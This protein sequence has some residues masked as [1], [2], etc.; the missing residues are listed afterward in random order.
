M[1][2][3]S[4]TAT[5]RCRCR[6]RSAT[7]SRLRWRLRAIDPPSGPD[8]RRRRRWPRRVL[9]DGGYAGAKPQTALAAHG[10]W[11]VAIVK[12]SD[13]A[14]GFELLPRGWLVER[15]PARHHRNRRLAKDF[16]ALIETAATWLMLASVKLLL[17]RFAR[18]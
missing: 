13:I 2:R 9:A 17:R 10:R 5:G 6:P 15:T 12:R 4:R 1:R 11:A 14:R 3:T 18:G 8:R 7:P 16:E